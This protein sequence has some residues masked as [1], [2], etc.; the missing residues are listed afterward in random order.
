VTGLRVPARQESC[1]ERHRFDRSAKGSRLDDCL[2]V[3]LRRF[4][5]TYGRNLAELKGADDAVDLKLTIDISLFLLE[6][7]R[8][9]DGS[10]V[11]FL[12]GFFALILELIIQGEKSND[13]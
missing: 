1:S 12:Y 13:E 10:H 5:S 9:V 6:V 11:G 3:K 7:G 4:E 2:P 8:F